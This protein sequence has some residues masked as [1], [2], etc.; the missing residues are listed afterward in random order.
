VPP[1]ER[2][3]RRAVRVEV[4]AIAGAPA[5][6]KVVLAAQR[7]VELRLGPRHRLRVGDILRIRRDEGANQLGRR[8]GLSAVGRFRDPD[9]VSRWAGG[10]ERPEGDVDVPVSCYGDVREL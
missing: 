4:A 2:V 8:K 9:R 6:G 10:L 3:A 7:I 5:G 1:E